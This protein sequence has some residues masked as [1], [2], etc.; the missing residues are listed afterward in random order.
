ML[1]KVNHFFLV[2]GLT[3]INNDLAM[4]KI[5]LDVDLAMIDIDFDVELWPYCWINVSD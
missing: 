5:D 4:I 3:L 1:I 2:S